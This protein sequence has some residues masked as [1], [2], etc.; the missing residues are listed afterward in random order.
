MLS[1]QNLEGPSALRADGP[2]DGVGARFAHQPLDFLALIRRRIPCRCSGALF[3]AP[4]WR[5]EK[6]RAGL[7]RFARS[8]VWMEYGVRTPQKSREVGARFAH[9]P[10]RRDHPPAGRMVPRITPARN[11]RT[12]TAW[13]RER[14]A[15]F[16][17]IP[18]LG[19]GPPSVPK[20]A[21]S[22]ERKPAILWVPYPESGNKRSPSVRLSRQ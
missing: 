20:T 9:Q 15:K 22:F 6:R 10:R 17:Q 21:S 3:E 18:R 1:T 8:E 5:C 11:S 4:F 12:R 19:T 7:A 2:V 13:E 14:A 16:V